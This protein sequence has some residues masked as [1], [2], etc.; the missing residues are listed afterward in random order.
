[1]KPWPH[2]TTA[3]ACAVVS[4]F[5]VGVVVGRSTVDDWDQSE[6]RS[7]S[8]PGDGFEAGRGDQ[9]GME[10]IDHTTTNVEPVTS[11]AELTGL[12]TGPFSS[13]THDARARL[14]ATDPDQLA[15]VAN[16]WLDNV[17]TRVKELRR[18]LYHVEI[19]LLVRWVEAAP[20]EALARVLA[21]PWTD[22][23]HRALGVVAQEIAATAPAS[24]RPIFTMLRGAGDDDRHAFLDGLA[25]SIDP[26]SMDEVFEL[27]GAIDPSIATQVEIELIARTAAADPGKA[28]ALLDARP[29]LRGK[30]EDQIARAWALQD[31]RAA[32]GWALEMEPSKLRRTVIIAIADTVAQTDVTVALE[33]FDRGIQANW[34]LC[35]AVAE[36]L[37]HG[38]RDVYADLVALAPSE[39]KD[40]LI[41]LVIDKLTG[42]ADLD[43]ATDLIAHIDGN[44]RIGAS[45]HLINATFS[46]DPERARELAASSGDQAFYQKLVRHARMTELMDAADIDAAIDFVGEA[47]DRK[48]RTRFV[49]T[50]IDHYYR[51]NDYAATGEAAVRLAHAGFA[52]D[53]HQFQPVF[54]DWAGEDPDAALDA[55]RQL[56]DATRLR[57]EAAI[58]KRVAES[59]PERSIQTGLQHPDQNVAEAALLAGFTALAYNDLDAAA[60]RFTAWAGDPAYTNTA[61]MVVGTLAERLI[62]QSGPATTA[63][64]AREL[65]DQMAAPAV[66]QAIGEWARH[67]PGAAS[68]FVAALAPGPVYN[69]A[70]TEL[71]ERI[72]RYD[73]ARSFAWVMS[74][75]APARSDEQLFDVVAHWVE[76][77]APAARDAV[78][79]SALAPDRKS[80][81]LRLIDDGRGL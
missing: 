41:K 79:R 52:T 47:D 56:P 19:D 31:P 50:I 29:V 13:L 78:S 51:H 68:A 73:P 21:I 67:D 49:E 7:T 34:H 66:A 5:A 54:S 63:K 17:A 77:D 48:E 37:R 2:T 36:Q 11:Y 35:G 22:L 26:G 76:I 25:S 44:N 58:W 74:V 33:L 9:P 27:T 16:E 39:A 20:E 46:R 53:L 3:K 61:T 18:V 40:G 80:S 32:A 12:R 23:R 71:V 43:V 62:D 81:L 72:F 55:A 6:T 64:W 15:A 4:A 24:V 69:D 38:R 75:S 65:P 10:R 45:R 70:A 28:L 1:M 59:D 30:V 14:A 60:D 42:T 8:A 57:I